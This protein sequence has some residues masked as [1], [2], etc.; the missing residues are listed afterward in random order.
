MLSKITN[1]IGWVGVALVFGAFA[2]RFLRPEEM[3]LWWN[4]AA[5]GLVC[6]LIYVVGQWREFVAFFSRRSSRYGTF[7]VVSVIVVLAS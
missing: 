3:S 4:P 2:L 1:L 6:V 5:A 7:S